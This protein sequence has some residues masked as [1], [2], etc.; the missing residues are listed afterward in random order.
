MIEAFVALGSNVGDR[1]AA[2][3]GAV[4]ALDGLRRTEVTA[5][6]AVY[7]TE[8]LVLPGAGPQPDQLNA[9]VR[10][11]TGLDPSALLRALHTIE[12]EAGR[13]P[14]APTWSPR[15]L[16]LDILLF[17]DQ[18]IESS[19]LVVPHPALAERRFV[20][21]PLAELAGP[22]EVAGLGRT[23]DQLLAMCPDRSRVERIALVLTES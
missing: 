8:A 14:D 7:E 18:R 21:E 12:R 17:G 5:T 10:L 20:L 6:S 23:V 11:S 3:R 1:L 15:P 19:G 9:V 13:A 2:L 22:V 16:D 4:T